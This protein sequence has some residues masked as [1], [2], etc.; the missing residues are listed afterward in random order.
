[1]KIKHKTYKEI[2]S[3][4][5]SVPPE[6]GGILGKKEDLIVDYI[7]DN[8]HPILNRAIYA[9]DTELLNRCIEEWSEKNIEFCGFVHS[10]PDGQNILS[11]GD[12]E[13][14]KLLYEVNPQLKNTYFPLI[15]N[16]R[17]L[18]VYSAERNGDGISVKPDSLEII[19]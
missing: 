14:I 19:E 11:S 17:E 16:G 2:L 7:H 8:T 4:Y 5:T 1:M 18:K 9:P 15:L 13:Y 3:H 6:C 12:M 10:H